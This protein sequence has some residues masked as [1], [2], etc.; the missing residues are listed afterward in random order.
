[1]S[2]KVKIG[3]LGCADIARKYAIKAFQAIPN[4]EVVSIASRDYEKAKA[5]AGEFNIK[6]EKSYDSLI[7]N[8]N[9][10]ALYI[11][12]PIGLHKEWVIKAVRKGQEND[13]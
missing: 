13:R 7:E 9:I 2:I 8:Q 10:D 3:I 1:M 12:L 6:A 11:P 5:W 4:A